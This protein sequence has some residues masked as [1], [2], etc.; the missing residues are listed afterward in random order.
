MFITENHITNL[1]DLNALHY[2]AAVTLAGVKEKTKKKDPTTPNRD[3]DIIIKNK[4]DSIRKWIGRLTS[5]KNN[6][7]TSKVKKFLKR[8][9]VAIVLTR[10]KM[11]LAAVAKKLKTIKA[12]RRRFQN[13]RLYKNNQKA[14]FA[15]LRDSSNK[16]IE[17]PPAQEEAQKYWGSLFGNKAKHNA[18][19]KW[20]AEEKEAMK[21]KSK[22]TWEDL[23]TKT[24]TKTTKKLANWKAPGIDRVQNFWIKHL[25]AL[26]PILTELCNTAITTPTSAPPWLTEGRTILIHKKGDTT[27][28]KNY[29]PIT[30]LPT[31]FK[32][33]TLLL[34]DLI[35]DHLIYNDILPAEQKGVRRK[36]RGCKDHLLLDKIITEDAKRKKRDLSVMW[37][38]YQKA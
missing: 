34:T 8:E 32:L 6:K 2:A 12:N 33:I 7:L 13:N 26:H 11:K 17:D 5:I 9:P 14:F 1:T 22:D 27:V 15:N 30:C 19:A 37:I 10:L 38:D 25:T 21:N 23:D 31:Y 16:L 35:Y 36:A 29:R 4:I 20:I 28:A 24:L 3:P 18:N